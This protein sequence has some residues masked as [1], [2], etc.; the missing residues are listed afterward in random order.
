MLR[1]ESA[2]VRLYLERAANAV[3]ELR[4]PLMKQRGTFIKPWNPNGWIWRPVP[5]SSNVW[6]CSS[7]RRN[8]ASVYLRLICVRIVMYECSLR[9]SIQRLSLKST[10]SDADVVAPS[11]RDVLGPMTSRVDVACRRR[12]NRPG[13]SGMPHFALPN[14]GLLRGRHCQAAGK[15][16]KQNSVCQLAIWL[17]LVLYPAASLCPYPI[18][19]ANAAEPAGSKRLVDKLL[20]TRLTWHR[21][22]GLLSAE[23][24]IVNRNPQSVWQVIITCDLLDESGNKIGSKSTAL[25]IPFPPGETRVSGIEFP[26]TVRSMH[27]GPCQPVSASAQ[28]DVS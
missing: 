21:G 2:A 10:S 16:S 19:A 1:K 26:M 28:S 15:K 20:V 5:R 3:N 7:K 23:A 12:R 8:F 27:G 18:M 4:P 11:M 25:P 22:G 13:E 9:P 6:I 24:T 14:R 17:G